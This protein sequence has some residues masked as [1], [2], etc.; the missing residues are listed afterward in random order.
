MVNM[1]KTL[2]C[3][4]CGISRFSTM[5]GLFSHQRSRCQGRQVVA[6]SSTVSPPI[7][8]VV[9]EADL[10]EIFECHNEMHSRND[11]LTLSH[12]RCPTEGS[13]PNLDM[14]GSPSLPT[15]EDNDVPLRP[16]DP[17]FH[18]ISFIRNCKNKQGLSRQDIKALLDLLFDDRFDPKVVTV[19]S[20]DDIEKYEEKEL[21]PIA[22]VSKYTNHFFL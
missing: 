9:G 12:E 13:S 22:D 5:A 19:R 2:V 11:L 3:T 16:F 10:V 18:L 4:R 1:D 20:V 8:G 14:L 6:N 17:T 7:A 21:Y 15:T